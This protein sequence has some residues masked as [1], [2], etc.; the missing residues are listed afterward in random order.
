[1]INLISTHNELTHIKV[2]SRN[3]LNKKLLRRALSK[4]HFFGG[5]E[6][7]IMIISQ[8]L[9]PIKTNLLMSSGSGMY[10]GV[11]FLQSCK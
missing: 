6:S 3:S 8:N 2:T 1:M 7:E 10:S 4:S 5:T 11:V 9:K